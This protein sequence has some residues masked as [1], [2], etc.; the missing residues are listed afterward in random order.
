MLKQAMKTR[1]Y[2]LIPIA[3]QSQIRFAS[4]GPCRQLKQSSIYIAKGVIYSSEELKEA[5]MQE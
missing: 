2:T 1:K 3:Q 5:A 4:D